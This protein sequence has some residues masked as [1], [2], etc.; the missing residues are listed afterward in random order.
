MFGIS[1]LNG[2]KKPFFR[3]EKWHGFA[4]GFYY[5]RHTKHYQKHD[6]SVLAVA[7]RLENQLEWR[8][9]AAGAPRGGGDARP[10]VRAPGTVAAALRGGAG[11]PQRPARGDG[12]GAEAGW[13]G[14]PADAAP[15]EP[16]GGVAVLGLPELPEEV[17]LGVYLPGGARDLGWLASISRRFAFP[18]LASA[19]GVTGQRW[20]RRG[21]PTSWRMRVGGG[22]RGAA[23][24]SGGG[25]VVASSRAGCV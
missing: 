23:S 17:L 2:V 5:E 6:L 20:R 11:A 1:P 7:K 24:R 8:P 25:Y 4:R 13:L 16:A 18:H 22:S 14:P 21:C 3:P 10:R 12:A 19:Q 15:V 9:C